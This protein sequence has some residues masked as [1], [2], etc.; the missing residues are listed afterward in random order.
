VDTPFD[1][2]ETLGHKQRALV[3]FLGDI[4]SQ[5]RKW[6]KPMEKRQPFPRA[7]IKKLYDK[8]IDYT[9]HHLDRM[10]NMLP[11]IFNW[12]VLGTFTGCRACEYAQTLAKRN[13]FAII[14]DSDAAAGWRGLPIAFIPADFIYID[15]TRH[16]IPHEEVLR[17]PKKARYLRL[18]FRFDKS[19]KN[20]TEKQYGPGIGWMCPILASISILRRALIL[21]TKPNE[22]LGVFRT[23]NSGS[24]T[25]IQSNDIIKTMRAMVVET[26]P[27]PTHFLRVHIKCIVAHSNRVTAA[28]ALRRAGWDVPDIAERLRWK[29]E[30]VG[31][32]LRECHSNVDELTIAAIKGSSQI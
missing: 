3:P 25:Y 30:S 8:V 4:I 23:S 19:G 22:P 17:Q 24:Y 18:R 21:G 29:P 12:I 26:Y 11:A 16:I 5:R 13:Q 2:Y 27:D 6:Q 31:H 28:V 32:Y 14:P 7:V 9:K 20:F 15:S 1:I 10:L